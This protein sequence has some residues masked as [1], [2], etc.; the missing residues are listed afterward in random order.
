MLNVIWWW[1]YQSTAP[2]AH[3]VS[4]NTWFSK[5]TN[6]LL[7]QKMF[8]FLTALFSRW[9]NLQH[10]HLQ[11]TF[12]LHSSVRRRCDSSVGC[13]GFILACVRD[14]GCDSDAVKS[15][16]P[17]SSC[18]KVKLPWRHVVGRGWISPATVWLLGGELM[19]M[20]ILALL[21]PSL[22]TLQ[23]RL[24]CRILV[25]TRR[26]G[27]ECPWRATDAEFPRGPRSEWSVRCALLVAK[28]LLNLGVWLEWTQS[29][30]SDS[31]VESCFHDYKCKNGTFCHLMTGFWS[32]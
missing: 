15:T 20:D 32:L 9:L 19:V 25:R 23:R 27:S 5:V 7:K 30:G 3:H 22:K 29:R 24:C 8:H 12:Y 4:T 18:L 21:L 31:V 28:G 16:S 11:N 10:L 14:D 13:S 26:D 6:H 1:Y 2:H 17:R